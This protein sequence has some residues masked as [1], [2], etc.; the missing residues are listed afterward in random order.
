MILEIKKVFRFA[1]KICCFFFLETAVS[2]EIE[3]LVAV[4]S[5]IL[6]K[7]LN[8]LNSAVLSDESIFISKKYK[9]ENNIYIQDGKFKISKFYF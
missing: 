1:L 4:N 6:I 3:E 2:N 8:E 9:M 5:S 7:L